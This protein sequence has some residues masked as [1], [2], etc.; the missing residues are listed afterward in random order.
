M[1]TCFYSASTNYYLFLYKRDLTFFLNF[2]NVWR[3]H[4]LC[5]YVTE[6]YD[7]HWAKLLAIDEILCHSVRLK[8][9][10]YLCSFCV[11][12]GVWVWLIVLDW[13]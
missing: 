9:V 4:I 1:V 10:E 2:P 3:H 7:S 5:M 13:L 12:F 11:F 6:V 8:S